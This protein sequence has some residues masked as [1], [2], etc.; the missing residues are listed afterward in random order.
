MRA[1]DTGGRFSQPEL[2]LPETRAIFERQDQ[3]RK[4]ILAGK[5]PAQ[6]CNVARSFNQKNS[7]YVNMLIDFTGFYLPNALAALD[8]L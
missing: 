4:K 1:S 5:K 6:L 8:R 2:I 3:R 7:L